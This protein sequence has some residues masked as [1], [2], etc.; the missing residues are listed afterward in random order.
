MHIL[1]VIFKPNSWC[2][3]GFHS[4]A[5]ETFERTI[6]KHK[7][8]VN[9]N[10]YR[11]DL[12]ETQLTTLGRNM[13]FQRTQRVNSHDLKNLKLDF[14]WFL[15]ASCSLHQ[16]CWPAWRPIIW[17]SKIL[18]SRIPQLARSEVSPLESKY[19]TLALSMKEVGRSSV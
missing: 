7:L 15:N 4:E 14:V 11:I 13:L 1:H 9:K 16:C 10:N 3:H 6:K 18:G 19:N 12:N 5:L 8:K 2:S 17:I